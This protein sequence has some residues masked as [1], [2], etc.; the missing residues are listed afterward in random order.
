MCFSKFRIDVFLRF[1]LFLFLNVWHLSFSGVIFEYFVINRLDFW[2]DAVCICDRCGDN[3]TQ[4]WY[5][6][7][8]S[9]FAFNV[10]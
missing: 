5:F 8:S 10:T 6:S 4:M 3:R 9:N 2:I 1:S 7:V